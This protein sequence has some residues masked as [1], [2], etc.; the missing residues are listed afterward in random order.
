MHTLFNVV[1]T[2]LL[3]PFGTYLA[4]FAQHILPSEKL[5]VDSEGLMYLQPLPKSNKIIGLSAINIQQVNDEVMRMMKLAYTN[6]SVPMYRM[7]LIS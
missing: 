4:A 2:L 5:S 1:T 6:V 7:P 3:L